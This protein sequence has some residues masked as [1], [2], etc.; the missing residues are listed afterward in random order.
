MRCFPCDNCGFAIDF[1]G[2]YGVGGCTEPLY[3]DLTEKKEILLSGIVTEADFTKLLNEIEDND[4][5]SMYENLFSS[6]KE[7]FSDADGKNVDPFIA[8]AFI[9][10]KPNIDKNKYD[11][12]AGKYKKVHLEFGNAGGKVHSYCIANILGGN[13]VAQSGQRNSTPANSDPLYA[14]FINNINSKK[15]IEFFNKFIAFFKGKTITPGAEDNFKHVVI[16]NFCRFCDSLSKK[17][18]EI[19]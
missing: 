3:E 16:G 6:C 9:F 1:C 11:K 8:N 12:K 18:N 15:N 13:M 17:Y 14:N 4:I 5:K 10:C 19:K 2:K 7:N